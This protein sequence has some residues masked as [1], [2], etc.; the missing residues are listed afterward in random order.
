MFPWSFVLGWS[1]LGAQKWKQGIIT[2]AV[3][4]SLCEQLLP[5]FLED[6]ILSFNSMTCEDIK[7]TFHRAFA[8]WEYNSDRL[9]FK[10]VRHNET[11]ADIHIKFKN[12][13]RRNVL[14]TA[15][16]RKHVDDRITSST[17][18]IDD[19][20]CWYTDNAFCHHLHQAWSASDT[21]TVAKAVLFVPEPAKS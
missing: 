5:K 10:E 19:S 2:Y 12:I 15:T 21:R 17:I 9:K 16:N 14:G 4:P 8:A 18:S 7:W 20:Y 3:E 1:S 11:S 13:D 6:R